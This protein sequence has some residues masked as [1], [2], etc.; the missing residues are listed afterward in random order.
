MK[1]IHKLIILAVVFLGME[2]FIGSFPSV[3]AFDYTHLLSSVPSHPAATSPS[4]YYYTKVDHPQTAEEIKEDLELEAY[5]EL[6]GCLNSSITCEMSQDYQEKV[7]NVPNVSE[8]TLGTYDFKY[9]AKD[10]SNNVASLIIHVIVIDDVRPTIH[11]GSSTLEHTLEVYRDTISKERICLGI[12]ATDNYDAKS[13]LNYEVVSG[14]Y[15]ELD[16]PPVGD[17]PVIVRVTDSSQNYSEVTVTIHVVD[18]TAPVI[19]ANQTS[20]T[21]SYQLQTE[22]HELLK[23]LNIRVTDN[24]KVS[25]PNTYTIGNDEYTQNL[26]KIGDYKVVIYA[27]DEYSN[28]GTL[29]ITIHIVDEIPPVFYLDTSKVYVSIRT[30][31]KK[32]DF[33][34][35]LENDNKI[36]D[37]F[38][39]VE[40]IEDTYTSNA[41]EEGEYL[42]QL[43]VLYDQGNYEDYKFFV[44]VVSEDI[45]TSAHKISFLTRVGNF[46]KKIGKV[47][48]DILRWPFQKLR[49]LF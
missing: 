23:T 45:P 46:F 1:T 28:V 41:T 38:Y 15:F 30:K 47:L 42:Y 2:M 40:V 25:D 44:H 13:D 29:E 12:E 21:Q 9:Q 14:N 16:R 26:G 39:R 35:L 24:Y 34:A 33:I 4:Y 7:L 10:S 36:K 17:Y 32:N 19:T 8:R 43:R 5:D 49:D 18:T 48:W 11:E 31:L 37:T 22:I 3:H 6:D 27:I 20:I